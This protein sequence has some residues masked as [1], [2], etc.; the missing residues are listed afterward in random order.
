MVIFFQTGLDKFCG[1]TRG[2]GVPCT[3]WAEE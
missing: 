3:F 1:T 2:F